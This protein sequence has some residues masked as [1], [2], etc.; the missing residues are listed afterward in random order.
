MENNDSFHFRDSLR[1][2]KGYTSLGQCLNYSKFP[3]NITLSFANAEDSQK[4]SYPLWYVISYDFTIR[5]THQRDDFCF[6]FQNE[7]VLMSLHNAYCFEH[8]KQCPPAG[9]TDLNKH[10]LVS[11]SSCRSVCLHEEQFLFLRKS[12]VEVPNG[13]MCSINRR[14]GKLIRRASCWSYLVG[15]LLPVKWYQGVKKGL[16]AF[17]KCSKEIPWS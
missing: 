12:L 1:K 7:W 16:Q 10:L 2:P 11:P 9:E 17:Y 8:Q 15:N 6:V 3:T 5:E 4:V 14:K 13:T